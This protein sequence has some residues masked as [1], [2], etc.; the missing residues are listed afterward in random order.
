MDVLCED[1]SNFYQ[2]C[3]AKEVIG[4]D[5]QLALGDSMMMT[6]NPGEILYPFCEHLLLRRGLWSLLLRNRS[7][8]L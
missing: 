3:G 5:I 7:K 6:G 8:P 2:A 1:D 4:L